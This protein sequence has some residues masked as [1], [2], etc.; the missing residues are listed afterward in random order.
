MKHF[1]LPLI[2]LFAVTTL[3]AQDLHLLHPDLSDFAEG[4]Q[5]ETL[6]NQYPHVFG[7]HS[8]KRGTEVQVLDSSYTYAFDGADSSLKDVAKYQYNE[9]AKM[10]MESFF[11]TASCDTVYCP[12]NEWRYEYDENDSLTSYGIYLYDTGRVEWVQFQSYQYKRDPKKQLEEILIYDFASKGQP[13]ISEKYTYTYTRTGKLARSYYHVYDQ[14]KKEWNEINR[15]DYE[16]DAEKRVI[17]VISMRKITLGYDTLSRSEVI[18]EGGIKVQKSVFKFDVDSMRFDSFETE[19]WVYDKNNLTTY[20][21]L[22]WDDFEERM[23][24]QRKSEYTTSS[25]GRVSTEIQYVR[26]IDQMSPVYKFLYTYYDNGDLKMQRDHWYVNGT[27]EMKFAW[28]YFRG[29]VEINSI[30]E[31]GNAIFSMQNDVIRVELKTDDKSVLSIY[32]LDGRQIDRQYNNSDLIQY[33]T[34]S[35]QQG[36][37]IMHIEDGKASSVFKFY[38]R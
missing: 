26:D 24:L 15:Y 37:Y 16:Y 4:H 30:Q 25:K 6:K 36:I 31:S 23:R 13:I 11:S 28:H 14:I 21:Y 1:L 5:M 7:T 33:S 10:T 32:G 20:E 22:R 19:N 2:L 18:Y 38:A 17:E 27:P 3:S 9:M 8:A 34:K 12:V 35:L 29:T